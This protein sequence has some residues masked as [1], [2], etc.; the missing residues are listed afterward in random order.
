MAEVIVSEL[1]DADL[2]RLVDFLIKQE[3]VSALAT[4]DLLFGAL[5]VLRTYPSIGRP[6]ED[7]LRE[8]VI[9]RGS[10]G[11]LA[12]YEYN[13]R[14]NQVVIL[15]LRHQREAGYFDRDAAE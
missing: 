6:V 13:I 15:V 10:T 12:L 11:Y 8:L 1:A 14:T 9:S 2:E 3:P 4:Y 5:E 7:G